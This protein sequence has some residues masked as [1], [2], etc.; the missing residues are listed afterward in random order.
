MPTAD[1]WLAD[2]GRVECP[3][4]D[5][6]LSAPFLTTLQGCI[7]FALSGI[8]ASAVEAPP[9]RRLHWICSQVP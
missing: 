4:G 3:T 5:Y 7:S 9:A 6:F 8:V 2:Y 1:E